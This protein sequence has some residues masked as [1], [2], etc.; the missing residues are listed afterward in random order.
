[1]LTN[2][3]EMQFYQAMTQIS[4][5]AYGQKAISYLLGLGAGLEAPPPTSIL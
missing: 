5:I 1:M 2:Q 3:V 4:V